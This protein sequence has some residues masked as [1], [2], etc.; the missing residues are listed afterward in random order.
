MVRKCCWSL[1]AMLVNQYDISNAIR[2]LPAAGTKENKNAT[3]NTKSGKQ[4]VWEPGILESTQ[5]SIN[6][7][8]LQ[9]NQI[10]KPL[11]C[12]PSI[13]A[14]SSKFLTPGLWRF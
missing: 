8:K 13:P 6:V 3:P 1:S 14:K 2:H 12:L 5:Q 9:Q 4:K 10:R 7:Q 11:I